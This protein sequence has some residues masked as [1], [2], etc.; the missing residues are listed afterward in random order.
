MLVKF[1]NGNGTGEIAAFESKSLLNASQFNDSRG[2]MGKFG[3]LVHSLILHFLLGEVDQIKA[4][5]YQCFVMFKTI[6]QTY[7]PSH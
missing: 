4:D 3:L 1:E 6:F 2:S 5:E 7:F